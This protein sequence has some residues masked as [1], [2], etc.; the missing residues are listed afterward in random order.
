MRNS[1]GC[2][3]STLWLQTA[4]DGE[5]NKENG[6][7]EEGERDI[8]GGLKFSKPAVVSYVFNVEY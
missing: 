8:H 6:L 3:L 1:L 2:E 7:Q 4:G 5:S